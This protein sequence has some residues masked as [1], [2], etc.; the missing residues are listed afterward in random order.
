MFLQNVFIVVSSPVISGRCHAF[1][2]TKLR[3]LRIAQNVAKPDD[4]RER[5]SWLVIGTNAAIS[6]ATPAQTRF[7][8]MAVPPSSPCLEP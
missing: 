2:I 3:S 8:C 6:S 4:P 5:I 1:P 7:S